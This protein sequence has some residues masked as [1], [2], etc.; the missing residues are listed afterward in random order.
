[1]IGRLVRDSLVYGVS[2]VLSK[3]LGLVLLVVYGRS[4]APGA[5]GALEL[6]TT[7]GVLVSMTVALEVSQGLGR[8]Y[9]DADERAKTELLS[10]AWWFSAAMYL[11]FV[12]VTYPFASDLAGLLFGRPDLATACRLGIVSIAL[13][14]TFNFLL[15]QFRWQL[16]TVWYAGMSI[17]YA[18]LTLSLT[19]LLTTALDLGLV[20]VLA[21]QCLAA[22][23]ASAAAL[24]VLRGRIGLTF[25]TEA[26]GRMLRFSI[27]LVPAGVAIFASMY[28]SR[29]ALNEFGTL[30]DVGV[31]GLANRIAG[32]AGLLVVGV[33]G[34]LTPLVYRHYKEPGTPGALATLFSWFCGLAL[35]LCLALGLFAGELFTL[36]STPRYNA[37]PRLLAVLPAALLLA[38][39]YIFAPGIAIA[40]KTRLQLLIV[41]ISGVVSLV[42]NLLLVPGLGSLGA[43]LATLAAAVVMFGLWVILSQRF[44]PVPFAW[45]RLTVAAGVFLGCLAAGLAVADLV[46]NTLVTVAVR[47]ALVVGFGAGLFKLGLLDQAAVRMLLARFRASRGDTARA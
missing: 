34:A 31:F 39:M 7:W 46:P 21:A 12:A 38:Q 14:A 4:L 8:H 11:V 20:G 33:Q 2:A 15:N 13:N 44:Y 36:F 25:A 9:A 30:H 41:T 1:M 26:L 10:T 17:A 32:I 28:L 37:D 47:A 42:F 5:F 16:Q 27:P 35:L 45:G 18:A 24:V 19:V 3:G 43:A 22:A 40:K 6:V 29:F 23:I